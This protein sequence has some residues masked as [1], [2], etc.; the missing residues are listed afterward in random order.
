VL[1]TRGPVQENGAGITLAPWQG[2]I[3]R[4]ATY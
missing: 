2:I 1:S 3:A 4:P